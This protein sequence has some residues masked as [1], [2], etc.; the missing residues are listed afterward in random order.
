M[1]EKVRILLADDHT[2]VRKGLAALLTGDGSAEVV[3]EASDG[4]ETVVLAAQLRPDVIIMD[5]AMPEM[6]GIEA[7]REIKAATPEVRILMLSMY[8]R[9]EYVRQ[10]IQAGADGY[11]LKSD[12]PEML[13]SAVVAIARG[14]RFFSPSLDEE[15]IAESHEAPRR[16][17][18]EELTARESEILQ[19]IAVGHSNREIADELSISPRTV[20]VHRMNLMKKLSVHNAPS[21]LR[22]AEEEGLLYPRA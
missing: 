20:A 13:V 21:L 10:S 22:R 7:T 14:E 6:S 2:I 4:K 15:L 19:L 1:T 16:R 8:D 17:G 12:A 3:G 18:S 11:L 9:R 5:I